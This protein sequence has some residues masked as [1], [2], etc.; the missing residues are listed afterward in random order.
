MRGR[1]ALAA[2]EGIVDDKEKLGLFVSRELLAKAPFDERR[3]GGA[4]EHA[5]G[6]DDDE[7]AGGTRLGQ[8]LGGQRQGIGDIASLFSRRTFEGRTELLFCPEVVGAGG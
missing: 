5:V 4:G 6:D 7:A 3:R 8:A 2:Q 1:Q